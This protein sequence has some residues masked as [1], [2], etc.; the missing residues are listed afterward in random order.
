M[1]C[2]IAWYIASDNPI[3]FAIPK[4]NFDTLVRARFVYWMPYLEVWAIVCSE[5]S[6]RT[7][8]GE[9]V[10]GPNQKSFWYT[11][12]DLFKKSGLKDLATYRILRDSMRINMEAARQ[13]RLKEQGE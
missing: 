4:R 3:A 9:I 5:Y 12:Q 11:E 10:G 6:I 2:V 8:G 13:Q 7:W 1:N